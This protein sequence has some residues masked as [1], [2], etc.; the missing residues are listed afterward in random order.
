ML[1]LW[2]VEGKAGALRATFISQLPEDHL[3][4]RAKI[5]LRAQP[6]GKWSLPLSFV[7][8]LRDGD[9][10]RMDI[11]SQLSGQQPFLM[12][13]KVGHTDLVLGLGP[14]ASG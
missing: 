12:G 14:R 1:V 4:P 2:F 7:P 9:C 13:S 10:P 8:R 5:S 11:Y 3:S 6:S